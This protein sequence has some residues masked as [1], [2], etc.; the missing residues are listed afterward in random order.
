MRVHNRWQDV[1]HS[2]ISYFPHQT[3][4]LQQNLNTNFVLLQ[5]TP[6]PRLTPQ[7]L[8]QEIPSSPPPPPAQ[9]ERPVQHSPSLVSTFPRILKSIPVPYS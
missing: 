3:K 9:A 1:Q 2:I 7:V 6:S 4:K 8:L 5:F